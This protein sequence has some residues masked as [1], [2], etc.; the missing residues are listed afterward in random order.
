MKRNLTLSAIVSIIFFNVSGGPYALEGVLAAGP[1]LG[2]SLIFL[3]PF[4][5][6]APIALVC[7][8]LGSTV[9]EEGGYYAW[10]KRSLGPFGGFCQGFW[11]WMFTAVNM[12]IY[13]TMFCD[14]LAYFV[15]EVGDGGIHWLRKTV[16]LSMIWGFVLLNLRGARAIG[17]LSKVF[18]LLVLSP[19]A[20]MVAVALSRGAVAV[21][22]DSAGTPFVLQGTT[23]S[24][25]LASSIPIILWNLLGWDSISTIAG[26]M[27]EPRRNYPKA[28]LIAAVLITLVYLVPSAVALFCRDAGGIEWKTG[29]WSIAAERIAGPWLGQFTSAMGMVAAAGLYSGLVL[30]SSRVPFVLAGDGFFPPM[31]TKCNRCD[32][33]WAALVTCGAIYS[34]VVLVFRN[35]DELAAADVTLYAAMLSMELLSFLVLRWKEPQLTRPFRVAGGWP[36]ALVVCT[37]PL[38]CIGAAAYYHVGEFGFR[39]VIGKPLV[40]LTVVPL[41]FP[42]AVRWRRACQRNL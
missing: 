17:N 2:L 16:M 25:A 29:A 1:F 4:I 39:N 9:P 11:A 35:V 23:L 40:A 20:C 8:E 30:V 24:A 10:A 19:F 3:A 18:M 33:P 34:G 15:P 14:Y 42:V 26:E 13:P 5:W 31:L 36:G 6:S 7:A 37:L 28:L 22:G 21:N 41:L 27:E 32:A 12:G 38:L